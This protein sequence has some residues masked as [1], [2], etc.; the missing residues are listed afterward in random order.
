MKDLCACY[1]VTRQSICSRISAAGHIPL[2]LGNQSFFMPE[3][4]HALD[5]AHIKLCEGF[6]LR[7]LHT[8][9]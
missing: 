7:D 9:S 1:G 6:S 8:I 5:D 3:M 4:V 2:K